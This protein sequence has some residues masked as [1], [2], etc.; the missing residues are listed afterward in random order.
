MATDRGVVLL[1]GCLGVAFLA[2]VAS[3]AI[4]FLA[5]SGSD[6]EAPASFATA[7]T[8]APFSP[9]PPSAIPMPEP[10]PQAQD[11]LTVEP[12]VPTSPA[13]PAGQL[14]PATVRRVVAQHMSDVRRCYDALLRRNPSSGGRIVVEFRIATTGRVDSARATEDGI[15]DA[16]MAT[17]L[18]SAVQQWTFPAP[19]GGP[20]TVSFPFQLQSGETPAPTPST[21][22]EARG[23]LPASPD[24]AS[25]V[26]AMRAVSPAVLAC[27]DGQTGTAS[28]RVRFDGSGRVGSAE[29]TSEPFAGTT[30]GSC[31]ERAVRAAVVPPFSGSS[32]TVTY[33]FVIR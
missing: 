13:E 1:F 3:V 4:W 26:A 25:I 30:A 20:V 11:P 24:R 27:G 22:P 31:I 29:V 2:L 9:T 23:T 5:S 10:A 16:A 17:C 32:M 12:S 33:P 6:V 21:S 7:Q 18:T 19:T 15:G 28:V 8:A 14:E